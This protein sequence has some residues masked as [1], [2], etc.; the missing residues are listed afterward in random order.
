ML[1]K[2]TLQSKGRGWGGSSLSWETLNPRSKPHPHRPSLPSHILCLILTPSQSPQA[3]RT[4]LHECWFHGRE[5]NRKEPSPGPG[6]APSF[7]GSPARPPCGLGCGA[8]PTVRKTRRG[9]VPGGVPGGR[10]GRRP[11]GGRAGAARSKAG[12]RPRPRCEPPEP[13]WGLTECSQD[14]PVHRGLP[15][16]SQDPLVAPWR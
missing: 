4:S 6:S 8:Q 11:E 13:K 3:A 15:G 2:Q 10:G 7:P 14:P 9:P 12:A 5:S 16:R 1:S